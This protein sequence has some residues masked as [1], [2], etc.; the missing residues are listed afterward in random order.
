MRINA[1]VSGQ[2][3]ATARCVGARLIYIST[4]AVF[5][6][7][8]GAYRETDRPSPVNHYGVSK[9]AGEAAVL[10]EMP[11]ALIL[12]VNIYGWNLQPKN[13][14]AEWGLAHLRKGE[15]ILGF[16]DVI[17]SPMLANEL[18]EWIL[19][20]IKC[21]C[22]GIYHLGSRDHATKYD[23]LRE[24]ADVF[25]LDGSLVREA[26]LEQ[27]PLTA[28]RPRNTWLCTDKVAGSLGRRLPTI[29]QGLETF[30][31]LSE[32]GFVSRLKAAAAA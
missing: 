7:A 32:S 26:L 25:Q 4:D 22:T 18:A 12:R 28:P 31:A 16:R 27:S 14:L 3:A 13:S 20:L 30:R 24:L 2:L 21:G 9:A 23:F 15:R 1:E 10:R 5:D 6:G 11:E 8:A 29:R 17:F 19:D